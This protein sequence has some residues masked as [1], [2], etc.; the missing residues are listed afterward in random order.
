M[1]R[2]LLLVLNSQGAQKPELQ[3]FASGLVVANEGATVSISTRI[4]YDVL[5][6]LVPSPVR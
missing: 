4:P 5:D 2:T 6:K 3:A 1:V